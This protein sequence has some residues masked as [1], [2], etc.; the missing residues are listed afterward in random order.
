MYLYHLQK[1]SNLAI[2]N[3]G[4]ETSFQQK[5]FNLLDFGKKKN[6]F[7]KLEKSKVMNC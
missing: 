5:N 2:N 1:Y 6:K 3:N 4:Y 7:V